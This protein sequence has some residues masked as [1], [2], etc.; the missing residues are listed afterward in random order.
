MTNA[1][2]SE[3][4]VPSAATFWIDVTYAV[5][6]ALEEPASPIENRQDA[7]A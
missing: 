1:S 3:H 6:A 2:A 7:H 5:E 4:A